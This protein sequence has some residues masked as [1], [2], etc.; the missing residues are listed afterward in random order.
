MLLECQVRRFKR[1][2]HSSKSTRF[3]IKHVFFQNKMSHE[4]KSGKGV[5]YYLNDPF[6]KVMHICLGSVK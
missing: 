2:Y 1:H 3:I 4:G 6:R 5:M